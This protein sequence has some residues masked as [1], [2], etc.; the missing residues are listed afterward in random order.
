MVFLRVYVYPIPFVIAIDA[1]LEEAGLMRR[2]FYLK[3]LLYA[4]FWFGGGGG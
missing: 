4:N 1:L 3:K 2:G